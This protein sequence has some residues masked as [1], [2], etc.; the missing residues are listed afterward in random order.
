MAKKKFEP[1]YTKEDYK[2]DFLYAFPKYRALLVDLDVLL[3]EKIKLENNIDYYKKS[4]IEK[5]LIIKQ[6]NRTIFRL[7]KELKELKK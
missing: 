3:K 7:R 5:N 4:D 2:I 1:V 6:K